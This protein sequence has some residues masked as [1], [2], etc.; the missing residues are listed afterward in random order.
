MA[1]PLINDFTS[2]SLNPEEQL[3]GEILSTLNK[4]VLQ[5]LAIMYRH[6][7]DNLVVDNNLPAE[8]AI[9]QFATNHASATGKIE[10]IQYLLD[11]SENAEQ[12]LV[13]LNS[14]K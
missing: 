2:Y 14:S 11:A 1:K 6:E 7:K 9:R 5:N 12:T 10:L 3:N 8:Q 13:K 4:M